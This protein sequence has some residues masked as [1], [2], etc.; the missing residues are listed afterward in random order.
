MAI[1]HLNRGTLQYSWDDPRVAEFVDNV[2]KVNALAARSPGFVWR[3]EDESA[4]IARTDPE[5]K[6]IGAPRV[7][8][9]LSMWANVASFAHFVEKTLH[10]RFL[11]KRQNWFE[12]QAGPSHV[13]WPVAADHRPSLGEAV[14][15]LEMLGTNGPTDAIFDLRY[16]RDKGWV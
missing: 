15:A 12:P 2:A 8:F 6:G 3:L 1:A 5:G 10:G 16:A 11:S 7:A 9:T 4:E 14:S 13:I